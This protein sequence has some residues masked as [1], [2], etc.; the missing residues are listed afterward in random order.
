MQAPQHIIDY[1]KTREGWETEVYIDTEGNPTA[2]M[3]HLLTPAERVIYAEGETV[4]AQVLARWTKA[5]SESAYTAAIAQS[6]ELGIAS[7]KGFVTVMTSVNYQLGI[8]WRTKFPQTW[9]AIKDKK[10]A[11]AARMVMDSKWA[12]QT[13]SRAREFAEA[14]QNVANA[15]PTNGG[16]TGLKIAIAGALVLFVAAIATVSNN[17]SN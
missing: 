6:T 11:V 17:L 1:L 16:R 15:K 8:Y 10:W 9:K 4:P 5:D 12:S 7:D 2:G 14:L 3:G 13:P